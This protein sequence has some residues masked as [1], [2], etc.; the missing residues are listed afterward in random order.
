MGGRG[1]WQGV[2]VLDCDCVTG[3]LAQIVEE[4]SNALFSVDRVSSEWV[5]DPNLSKVDRSCKSGRL[6][7]SWDEFHVLNS[8]TL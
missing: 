6:G 5:N 1:R 2:D 8:S 3:F 7:I 4:L